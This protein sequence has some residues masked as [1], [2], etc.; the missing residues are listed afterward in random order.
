MDMAACH[1]AGGGLIG[2]NICIYIFIYMESPHLWWGSVCGCHP[3]EYQIYI[4]I[5]IHVNP[6][7]Y[8]KQT[9]LL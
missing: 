9:F 2:R 6:K 5:Y 8:I 7:M 3:E 1:I 4:Y